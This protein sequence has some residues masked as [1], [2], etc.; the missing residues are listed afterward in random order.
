V[1]IGPQDETGPLPG[2][3]A[4][5][6]ER[7]AADGSASPGQ[8]LGVLQAGTVVSVDSVT[9]T[10]SAVWLGGVIVGDLGIAGA[11]LTVTNGADEGYVARLSL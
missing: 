4:I 10:R 6:V 1:N 9:A 2:D 11:Q 8:T 7:F 3:G 5:Y